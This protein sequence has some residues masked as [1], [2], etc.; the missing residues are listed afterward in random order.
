MYWPN[1]IWCLFGFIF[2]KKELRQI[3]NR[4][5]PCGLS[6]CVAGPPN[7]KTVA[8]LVSHGAAFGVQGNFSCTVS[9]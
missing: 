7:R 8:S 4:Q 3:T 1:R 2:Y 5:L 6:F 9:L